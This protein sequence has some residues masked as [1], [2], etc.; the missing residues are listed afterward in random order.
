MEEGWGGD[1]ESGHSE[2]GSATAVR[3][4]RL[5]ME[6]MHTIAAF[7]CRRRSRLKLTHLL[8]LGLLILDAPDKRRVIR[9]VVEEL[10]QRG[11]IVHAVIRLEKLLVQLESSQK[12]LAL[13]KVRSHTRIVNA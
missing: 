5:L 12:E 11:Y 13:K 10:I 8:V 9:R 6:A 3:L 1:G 2:S 4:A 7:R